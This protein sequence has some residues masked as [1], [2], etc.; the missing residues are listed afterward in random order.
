MLSDKLKLNESS[1]TI[2]DKNEI[3]LTKIDLNTFNNPELASNLV[4][5]TDQTIKNVDNLNQILSATDIGLSSYLPP[6][7]FYDLITYLHESTSLTWVTSI[8]ISCITLRIC[9]FPLYVKAKKESAELSNN[10]M[11][12]QRKVSK[13]DL[14]ASEEEKLRHSEETMKSIYKVNKTLPRFLLSPIAQAVVFSS[15]YFCLRAMAQH[16]IQSMKSESFLW[17]PSLTESDPYFLFPFFTAT[18]MFLMLK[19]NMETSE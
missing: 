10:M 6:R 15:F 2:L 1:G 11:R 16:P 7:L 8:L 19:F 14:N 9:T 18:T 17:V 3:D 13:I 12:M 4:E 5:T